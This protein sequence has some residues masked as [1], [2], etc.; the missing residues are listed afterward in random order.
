[1][2]VLVKKIVNRPV[3]SNSYVLYRGSTSS[4]V[5]VDPGTMDCQELILFMNKSRL[6]PEYIVLTHEH[7]DHIWG[8]NKLKETF[9]CQ[10][11]CSKICSG[12]ISDK[13]KNLSV[14]YDQVGFRTSAADVILE[15][16]GYSLAWNDTELKFFDTKG[17][18]D[19]S[20]CMRVDGKLFTGDSIIKNNKTVVKLPGG[21][22]EKLRKSLESLLP[23][24]DHQNI[25]VYSGHGED[26]LLSE[27]KVEELL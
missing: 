19:G 23:Q 8:V 3:P 13:K 24:F 5:V 9:G 21:S 6:N 20:V 12:N 1:M 4:C 17:H 25:G 10:T 2:S 18:T 15:D 26:F 7:F 22:K 11:V 14:F 27:V 16:I